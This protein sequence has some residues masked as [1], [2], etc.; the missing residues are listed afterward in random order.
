MLRHAVAAYLAFFHAMF[1]IP[2]FLDCSKP[3]QAFPGWFRLILLALAFAGGLYFAIDACRRHY[4]ESKLFVIALA[5]L[6]AIFFGSLSLVYYAIWGRMPLEPASVVFGKAFCP[7]CLMSSSDV[8]APDTA[9]IN[10]V[11]GTKLIGRSQR[12][13]EC[14]SVVKTLWGFALVPLAPGGSYRVIYVETNKYISRKT[15]LDLKN[16]LFVYALWLPLASLL[17]W[18]MLARG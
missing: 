6:G 16:V 8:S 17:L 13:P 5:I 18:W 3:M 4:T 9:T 15:Q 1:W 10:L 12:C 14:G 7:A 2:M 11:V